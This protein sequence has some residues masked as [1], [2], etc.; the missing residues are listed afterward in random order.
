MTG[1][2]MTQEHRKGQ[3]WWGGLVLALDRPCLSVSYLA[4]SNP[5]LLAEVIQPAVPVQ[6]PV[7][8]LEEHIRPLSTSLGEVFGHDLVVKLYNRCP[9]DI[10]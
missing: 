6:E 9:Q 1:T 5:G 7:K 2:W 3:V 8:P 10:V 4:V